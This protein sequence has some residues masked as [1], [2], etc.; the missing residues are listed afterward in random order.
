MPKGIMIKQILLMLFLSALM[1]L[2]VQVQAARKSQI[3]F[4]LGQDTPD[5]GE[6]REN[7]ATLFRMSLSTEPSWFRL[8]AG[9]TMINGSAFMQGEFTIGPYIYPLANVRKTPIQPFVF[10]EGVFGVGTLDEEARMDT[11]MGM[12]AGVDWRWGKKSGI[13]VAM[14][15]HTATETSNRIWLGWFSQY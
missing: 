13:T 9:F 7:S 5:D 1:S 10:A 6:A 12:G 15:L 11:G 4:N 14:E 2:P 3:N 8:V